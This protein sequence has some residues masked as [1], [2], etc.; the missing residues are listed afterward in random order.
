MKLLRWWKSMLRMVVSLPYY[1]CSLYRPNQHPTSTVLNSTK[2][3]KN[4]VGS[5]PE[6]NPWPGPEEPRAMA[7]KGVLHKGILDTIQGNCLYLRYIVALYR[8]TSTS[9]IN[10]LK[11]YESYAEKKMEQDLSSNLGPGPKKHD[12]WLPRACWTQRYLGRIT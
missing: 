10:S 4:E 11:E 8:P 5:R 9:N 12:P 7:P 3:C 6:F 1:H 2:A